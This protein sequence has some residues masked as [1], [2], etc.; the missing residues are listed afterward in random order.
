MKLSCKRCSREVKADKNNRIHNKSY[1][2]GCLVS[3][4]RNR[5]KE[6]AIK[7]KGGECQHCGYK[8]CKRALTFHHLDPKQKSFSLDSN[9]MFSLGWKTVE[10]ELNK[11]ILLCSN[12]HFELH[13]KEIEEKYKLK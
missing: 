11:C 4:R 7:F 12:C 10:A 9:S 13:D 2:L 8:K 5:V 3:V 1:C 6:K